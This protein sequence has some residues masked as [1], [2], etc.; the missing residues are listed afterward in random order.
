M[1]GPPTRV[2][3]VDDDP[4]LR[5]AVEQLLEQSGYTAPTFGSAEAFLSARPKLPPGCIIVDIVMG[6]MNGLDLQRRLLALGCR[7]PVIILTGRADRANAER[8]VAAGAV[9]FLE[10]PVRRVELL[11]AIL[12]GEGYLL[13][14][15]EATPDPE[16]IRRVAFLTPRERHV[17]RGVLEAKINKEM[18]A[19][20]GITESAVKSY[21]RNAMKKLGARTPAELVMLALRAGFHA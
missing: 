20:F 14:A 3:V 21:R 7:W 9:S 4:L 18:A 5:A 10:K 8:A 2:Y 13:G 1:S 17:L 16:L 6:G 19:E 12:K 11:A 15:R